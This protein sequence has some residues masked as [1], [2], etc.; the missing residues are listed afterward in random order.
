MKQQQKSLLEYRGREFYIVFSS[1]DTIFTPILKKNFSHCFV[2]EKLDEV[3]MS[4]DP[5]RH[6]LNVAVPPCSAKHDLI[7][8]MLELDSS[9]TV[10]KMNTTGEEQEFMFYPCIPNCVYSCLYVM[11]IRMLMCFTP[12]QLYKRLLKIGATICQLEDTQQEELHTHQ[13]RPQA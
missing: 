1:S 7:S 12:Y 6:E 13:K 9:I 3:W 5:T 8:A 10:L 4:Y 2:V 11:G